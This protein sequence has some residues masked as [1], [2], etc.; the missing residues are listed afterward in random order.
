MWCWNRCCIYA[1]SV[2]KELSDIIEKIANLNK[3]E[4]I[5]KSNK[6]NKSNIIKG[7]FK[8]I[9]LIIKGKLTTKIID[10]LCYSYVNYT[11]IKRVFQ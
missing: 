7:I 1:T 5:L 8:I 6:P 10:N 2:H 11:K 4:K 3:K 9:D